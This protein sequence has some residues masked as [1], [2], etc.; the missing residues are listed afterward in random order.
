MYSLTRFWIGLNDARMLIQE[1]VVVS[2]T[3]TSDRPST[4][5]WY[6][7]PNRGIQR[8]VSTNWKPAVPVA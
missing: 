1:S 7:M 5:T 6:W 4:P 2:T 3:R 8:Y